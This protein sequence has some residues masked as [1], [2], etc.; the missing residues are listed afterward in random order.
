MLMKR[1]IFTVLAILLPF[2]GFAGLE[3][4]LGLVGYG[5]DF[6]LVQ[7]VTYYGK[8]Y[9]QLNRNVGKRYFRGKYLAVPEMEPEVFAYHKPDNL[10]RIFVL[11]GSTSASF[12]FQINARFSQLLESRLNQ[13]W[14]GKYQFEV[15]NTGLSAIN[16]YSVLDMIQELINYQ[17]DLFLIYMGHNEFYGAFGVGSTERLGR[18]R[19]LVLLY[20]KLNRLRIFRLLRSA[21]SYLAGLLDSDRFAGRSRATLMENMVENKEIRLDSEEYRIARETFRKNLQ[22]ILRIARSA[23]AHV[24][25]CTLVRNEKDQPP[26]VSLFRSDLPDRLRKEWKRCYAMAQHMQKEGDVTGAIARLMEALSIDS[27]RAD[28]LFL[29]GRLELSRGNVGKARRYLARAA[30]LDALRFRATAEWNRIIRQVAEEEGVSLI[31]IRTAFEEN[32]PQGIPGNE[33]LYEHLHPN[34]R[35]YCLMAQTILEAM[36][37]EGVVLPSSKWPPIPKIQERE[38]MQLAGVTDVDIRLADW[39]I[40]R[41]TSRWPFRKD[42]RPRQLRPK[43]WMDSLAVAYLEH[44]I[45]WN[46]VHYRAAEHYRTSAKPDSAI[47]EYL[48]VA[49]V[50][51]DAYYPLYQ[52]GVILLEQKR[53]AEAISYLKKAWQLNRM[54]P[55]TGYRLGTAL[56]LT[57]RA[58]EAKEILESVLQLEKNR[59]VLKK[60]EQVR[61]HY[62][63][64][65][66]YIQVNE[67]PKAIDLLRWLQ[68]SAP[69]FRPAGILLKKLERGEKIHVEF[70]N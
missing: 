18:N 47:A 66:A 35:G 67:Y 42:I 65:L 59:S 61:L 41:L 31:D 36:K 28:G 15:I 25:L 32:S 49:R 44:R 29:M 27:T 43:T 5:N 40:R 16:S 56:L 33:L 11:G 3:A 34:F 45:P 60:E 63:L 69:S 24:F 58:S 51:P 70:Q 64:S 9:Y 7:R 20:L 30:D 38:W 14:N 12:P 19:S 62:A 52:A 8:T 23:G 21:F 39:R 1:R 13:L 2:M 53:P 50:R 48:A 4:L 10:Y 57:G 68:K 54:S 46:Q 17:P 26:F 22:A 6:R 37:R 55:Y